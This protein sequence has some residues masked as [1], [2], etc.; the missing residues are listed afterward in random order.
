VRTTTSDPISSPSASDLAA[1]RR[2]AARYDAIAARDTS[3]VGH[4]F[5][6]V[7]TT[8]VYCKPS[9]GARLPKRENVSFHESIVAAEQAGFRP[10][11]RC[12]P[13]REVSQ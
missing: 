10:C 12:R 4:W 5:Y 7:Q 3:E 1:E 8:G 9:C 6:A 2:D 11:K 13:D